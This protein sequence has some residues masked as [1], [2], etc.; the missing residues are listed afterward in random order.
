MVH[1]LVTTL[2]IFKTEAVVSM[3]M[4]T[5][6]H[7]SLSCCPFLSKMTEH[8]QVSISICSV[9]HYLLLNQQLLYKYSSDSNS[10]SQGQTLHYVTDSVIWHCMVCMEI[11]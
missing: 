3:V 11:S 10:S 6:H 2:Q 7:H 4:A 5:A 8:K 9:L 1:A